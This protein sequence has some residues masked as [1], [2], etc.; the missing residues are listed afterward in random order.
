MRLFLV[1]FLFVA[2]TYAIWGIQE[3]FG[4][5][6]FSRQDAVKCLSDYVDTNHD[7]AISIAELRIA[8]KRFTPYS[9][10]AM[11]WLAKKLHYDISIRKVVKDCR[12]APFPKDG[13]LD[14]SIYFTPDDF[15][16]TAKTCLPTQLALCQLKKVC[17]NAAE[18]SPRV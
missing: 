10:Q 18:D 15:L 17:D 8:K 12:V 11:G 16:K 4:Y 13:K 7:G 6:T 3:T 5:C 1:L 14:S 9:L 2:E